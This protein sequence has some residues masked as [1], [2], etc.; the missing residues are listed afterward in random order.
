MQRRSTAGAPAARTIAEI[1][2][3]INAGAIKI[4]SLCLLFKWSTPGQWF[5]ELD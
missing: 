3:E 5:D 1:I 4:L 2:D